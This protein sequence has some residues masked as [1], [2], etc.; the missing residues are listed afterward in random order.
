MFSSP[1]FQNWDHDTILAGTA[2]FDSSWGATGITVGAIIGFRAKRSS[3]FDTV[4]AL[5][6][7]IVSVYI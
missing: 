5:H 3:F 1:N 4:L 2:Q 7:T 6:T